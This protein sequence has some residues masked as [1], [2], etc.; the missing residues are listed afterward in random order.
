MEVVPSE[1]PLKGPA[2]CFEMAL[3]LPKRMGNL[4]QGF[5]IVWRQHF[6]LNDRKVDFH[7]IEPTAVNGSVDQLRRG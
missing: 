6:S 3:E 1:F 2:D 5:E 7:L 4:V